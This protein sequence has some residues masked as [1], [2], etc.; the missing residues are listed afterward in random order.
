MTM[1]GCSPFNP[2]PEI[3]N[4]F[5][6]MPPE[7][8]TPKFRPWPF[9]YGRHL[10]SGGAGPYFRTFLLATGIPSIPFRELVVTTWE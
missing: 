8:H 2:K 4:G 3:Q 6:S 7:K 10:P 9:H 5:G 1:C